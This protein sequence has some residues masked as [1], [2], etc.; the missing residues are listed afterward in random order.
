MMARLGSQ[1][2]AV[3]LK[4][5]L[6]LFI[7]ILVLAFVVLD[8]GPLRALYNQIKYTHIQE[9]QLNQV[10]QLLFNLYLVKILW[11]ALLSAIAIGFGYWIIKP[12]RDKD[13]AAKI[14]E[15]E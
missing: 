14:R 10:R 4:V 2:G 13:P 11:L 5:K 1:A 12:Y 7:L 15:P 8:V 3:S 6:A 9:A